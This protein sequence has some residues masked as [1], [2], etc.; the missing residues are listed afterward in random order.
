MKNNLLYLSMANSLLVINNIK[1]MKYFAMCCKKTTTFCRKLEG[2]IFSG[3]IFYKI[4]IVVR[5][6]MIIEARRLESIRTE[7]K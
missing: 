7:N 1:Y 6:I 3:D 2:G 5:E 4:V